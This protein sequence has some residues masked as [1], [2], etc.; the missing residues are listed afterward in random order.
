LDLGFTQAGVSQ[1]FRQLGGYWLT[2][3]FTKERGDLVA[4]VLG[5]DKVV[6]LGSQGQIPFEEKQFDT[7]VVANRGVFF[8]GVPL[9]MLIKECHRVLIN[10]GL[11]VF[12]F[13]RRKAVALARLLGGRRGKI[14]AQYACT[15]KEVL[16]LLKPGFD[17][18]GIKY[19]GRFWIELVRQFMEQNEFSG[20]CSVPEWLERSLYGFASFL[21]LPLFFTG[22][23]NITVCGRRKGWR[24]QQRALTND[25]TAAVS[26]ALFYDYKRSRKT[27]SA[28]RFK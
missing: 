5:E 18:L 28:T 14:E 16:S 23:Y 7:I 11:F 25:Q 3:E 22:H 10:G 20:K 9:E 27:F 1:M 19:S 4:A 8:D 15:Y 12:T 13:P 24:G 17:V 21:D 26:N 6:V 2:A